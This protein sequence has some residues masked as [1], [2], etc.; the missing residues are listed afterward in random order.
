MESINCGCNIADCLKDAG[1][2]K[3]LV[4]AFLECMR[5]KKT[6]GQLSILAKHRKYLLDSL[7]QAQ[8]E[9]DCLDYII[10]K[11]KKNEMP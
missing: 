11:L 8:E 10:Y 3:E 5:Q 2:S 4:D 9:I 1:C 6:S 7:H